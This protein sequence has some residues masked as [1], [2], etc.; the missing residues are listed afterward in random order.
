MIPSP[1][2]RWPGHA[3]SACAFPRLLLASGSNDLEFATYA[4]PAFITMRVS[5]G[6]MRQRAADHLAATAAGELPPAPAELEAVML[7]RTTAPAIGPGQ[8]PCSAGSMEL[9]AEA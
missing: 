3:R 4:D 5:A 1:L 8:F 6:A 2:A 7:R 9:D